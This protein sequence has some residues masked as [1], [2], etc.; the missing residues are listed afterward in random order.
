MAKKKNNKKSFCEEF[1]DYELPPCAKFLGSFN[2]FVKDG[3]VI[4][5]NN[6]RLYLFLSFNRNI[7]SEQ[8][9]NP[10]DP[11]TYLFKASGNLQIELYFFIIG[12]FINEVQKGNIYDY[13][14]IIIHDNSDADKFIK[15][16]L[17]NEYNITTEFISSLTYIV[18]NSNAI[19]PPFYGV[20][21]ITP[22]NFYIIL[23]L[24]RFCGNYGLLFGDNSF[25]TDD[26]I[27]VDLANIYV[28]FYNCR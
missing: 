10:L 27:N 18:S 19:I 1:E 24:S 13:E 7:V 5:R 20:I 4:Y 26:F 3:K 16:V 12:L 28:E 9:Y 15:N 25:V 22:I 21:D 6:N 17:G 11:S 2:P 8:E 14:N 23:M